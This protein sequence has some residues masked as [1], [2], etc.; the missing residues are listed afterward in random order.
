MSIKKIYPYLRLLT[1]TFLV[2]SQLL[3]FASS[4][5]HFFL[6]IIFVLEDHL[7]NVFLMTGSASKVVEQSYTVN[8]SSVDKHVKW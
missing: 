8:T 1:C 5:S 4:C 2:F 3:V 7:N 6:K